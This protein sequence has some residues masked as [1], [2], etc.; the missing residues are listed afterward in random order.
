MRTAP[1]GSAPGRAGS[2]PGRRWSRGVAFTSVFSRRDGIIDWRSCLDPQA[3]TVE[4]ATSHLGMAFDP[5]VLDVVAATLAANRARRDAGRSARRPGWRQFRTRR[6][7][8]PAAR[9][10]H[11]GRGRPRPAPAAA[12][13]RRRAPAARPAPPATTPQSH[14][15]ASI[16]A[17]NESPAPTRVHDLG[18]RSRDRQRG[19]L[20]EGDR[21][22]RPAGDD[23]QLGGVAGRA[24]RGRRPPPRR[25]GRSSRRSSSVSLTSRAIAATSSTS[26]QVGLR[27]RARNAGRMFGS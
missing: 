26:A 1:P 6:R 16:A 7:V 18:R 11:R 9:A 2:S 19:A 27:G 24:A 14:S 22:V 4:V 25:P 3:K 20:G 5:V 13:G 12:P 21:P 17:M 10:G 23:H 8:S 15:M